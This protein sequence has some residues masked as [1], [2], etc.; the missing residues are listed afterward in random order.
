MIINLNNYIMFD[1]KEYQRSGELIKHFLLIFYH[2]NK[3]IYHVKKCLKSKIK[4]LKNKM[5]EHY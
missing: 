3:F 1:D 2:F 5:C 4:S